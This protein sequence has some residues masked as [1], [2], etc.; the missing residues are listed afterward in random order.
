M[1]WQGAVA[2]DIAE[3]NRLLT[4][5][6]NA[7]VQTHLKNVIAAL[8]KKVCVFSSACHELI[9]FY[10]CFCCSGGGVFSIFFFACPITLF[11]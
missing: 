9:A 6:T 8:G 1:K 5:T 11:T 2:T 7:S 4:L 3:L 10:P